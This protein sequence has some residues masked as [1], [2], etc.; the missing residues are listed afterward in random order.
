MAALFLLIPIGLIV[1]H[2]LRIGT[3]YVEFDGGR[4][5]G[6]GEY[7]VWCRQFAGYNTLHGSYKTKEAAFARIKWLEDHPAGQVSP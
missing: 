3:F 7:E 1:W 2:I 5:G 6:K 4:Y